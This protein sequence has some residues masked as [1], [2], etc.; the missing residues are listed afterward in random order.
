MSLAVPVPGPCCACLRRGRELL[1]LILL[2]LR[3]L[4]PGHGWGCTVCHLPPHGAF[5]AVCDECFAL[6]RPILAACHGPA[7][8]RQ[9]IGLN[10]LEVP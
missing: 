3:S 10:R 1:N 8:D 5:A 6:R 2:P 4:E 9:R 7:K